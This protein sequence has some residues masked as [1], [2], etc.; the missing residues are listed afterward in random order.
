MRALRRVIILALPLMLAMGTASAAPTGYASAF[1]GLYEID[2][3]TA[4]ATKVGTYGPNISDIEGLTYLPDGTLLGVSDSSRAL[5]RISPGSSRAAYMATFAAELRDF[6]ALDL[7]FAAGC[8]GTLYVSSDQQR[9]LWRIGG[10][11]SAV[12]ISDLPAAIS[13]LAFRDGMLYGVAIT[14]ANTTAGEGLWKIDPQTGASTLL[15]NFTTPRPVRDAGLDFDATGRLWAVFDYNPPTS[16]GLIDFSDVAELD[17]R[18]GALI[19]RRT[20]TSIDGG[21]DLEG[22]AVAP[23]VC[24]PDGFEPAPALPIPAG[25]NASWLVLGLGFLAAAFAT[26]RRRFVR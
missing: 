9:K 5:Y 24:R 1:D 18:N 25:S 16:G 26:L 20:V 3:A 17:P 6:T 21:A 2:L 13:G 14:S 23:P 22:L 11:G 12:F 10:D 8:D 4:Q 19:S 7:G 15:G